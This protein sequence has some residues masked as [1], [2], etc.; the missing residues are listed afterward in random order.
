[1]SGVQRPTV[2]ICCIASPEEAATAIHYGAGAL[3]LVSAMPS[4]PGVLDE[5]AI[6]EIV[7]AVPI[8][9]ATFLL[10]SSTEAE[11]I[12]A[13]Q[14]RTGVNTIQLVDRLSPAILGRLRELLPDTALVQVVHVVGTRALREAELVTPWVDAI[15]LDS[16]NP[17]LPVKELGGTGRTH[18]WALSRAIV[19]HVGC[20]V[21]LAG[22]LDPQNVRAAIETVAPYGVD[23]CSGVRVEGRLDDALLEQ[24]MMAVGEARP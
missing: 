24:F 22:G 23:L 5:T 16:G 8:G 10:T 2:K 6:A 4:G 1:M 21:Y 17:E 15:L 18:D 3:G 20:P 12:A 9:I 19:E 7:A 14:E 13:Q 11:E